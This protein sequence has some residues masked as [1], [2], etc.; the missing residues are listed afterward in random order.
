MR[1]RQRFPSPLQGKA[2]T[3]LQTHAQAHT[4]E[5]TCTH[6]CTYTHTYTHTH[7]HTYTHTHTPIRHVSFFSSSSPSVV[8]PTGQYVIFLL[9]SAGTPSSS[10]AMGMRQRVREACILCRAR[11]SSA[12]QNSLSMKPLVR[13]TTTFLLVW[14][15]S[16]MLESMVAPLRKSLSCQQTL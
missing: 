15:A 13:T 3:P 2:Q 6:T 1:C 7:T 9:S 8:L 14:T 12:L 4:H 5:Y 10:R 11:S 16:E